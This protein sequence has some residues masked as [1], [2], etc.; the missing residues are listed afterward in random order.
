M[1]VDCAPPCLLLDH[2]GLDHLIGFRSAA[3]MAA[4]GVICSALDGGKR[5]RTSMGVNSLYATEK[6][7]LSPMCH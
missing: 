1:P 4:G 6:C 7:N 3:V 2:G 5:V